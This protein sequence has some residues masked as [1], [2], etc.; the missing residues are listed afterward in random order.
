M[1]NLD[2]SVENLITLHWFLFV[3]GNGTDYFMQNNH[4]GAVAW[5]NIYQT[6]FSKLRTEIAPGRSVS[7]DSILSWKKWEKL[8]C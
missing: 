7:K 4:A 5:E 3:G 1:Y 6:S 8:I 2:N